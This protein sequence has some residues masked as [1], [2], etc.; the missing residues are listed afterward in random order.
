MKKINITES[1]VAAVAARL[2]Q[3]APDIPTESDSR[4]NAVK[5]IDCVLSLHPA[6]YD[7]HVVPRL[8]TFMNNRPDTK[9]VVD[10]ANLM[11]SY[12]TSHA[13]M[14]QELNYKS[15]RKARILPEVVKFACQI[16]QKTPDVPEEETLKKWAT[17]AKPQDHRMLNIKGFA[18]ASF[19]Y[20]RILFGA[21][22]IK[23]D[24]H[25][26]RF[27]FCILSRE[28]SDI[29]ALFLLKAASKHAGLSARAVDLFIWNI[30]ANIVRLA[31]DV[32]AAFPNEKAVNETLRSVLKE[33]SKE[34]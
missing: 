31:P 3:P 27:I 25:I 26:K 28:V 22:T 5:V 32:A 7:N 11:T 4:P 10:L 17:Q 2:E 8:E 29:E 21:D 12:R 14:K 1:D 19:Q 15:K 13:F 9:R 6:N 34:R 24:V 20:L 16:I 33:R 23:P 30:G 18:L